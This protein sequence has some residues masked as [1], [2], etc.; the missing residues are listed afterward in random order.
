MKT[1]DLEWF[2]LALDEPIIVTDPFQLLFIQGT[3]AEVEVL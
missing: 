2:S 1:N 3:N